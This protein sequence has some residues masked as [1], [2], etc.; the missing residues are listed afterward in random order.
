MKLD[1]QIPVS[2][3]ELRTSTIAFTCFAILLSLSFYIF[4]SDRQL[5]SSWLAPVVAAAFFWGALSFLAFH[6]FWDIYYQYFY[7]GWLRPLAL[8][9]IIL[10]GVI[11][12]GMW[13]TA[14]LL[15]G[16]AIL[17]F[18]F[19]GGLEGVL[20]HIIGVYKF[21]LLQKVPWLRGLKSSHVLLFSFVEYIVYWALV[22]WITRGIQAWI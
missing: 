2:H 17:V 8:V 22:L 21:D 20:E 14:Q 7:P 15:E 13:L 1:P 18:L 10:Y 9:N 12:Y 6:Y 4:P 11:T 3:T 16:Y 5:S 19:L